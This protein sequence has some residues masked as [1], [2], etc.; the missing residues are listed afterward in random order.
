MTSEIYGMSLHTFGRK[1]II[2]QTDQ[3]RFVRSGSLLLGRISAI[4][5]YSVRFHRLCIVTDQQLLSMI[6]DSY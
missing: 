6:Q 1:I 5:S 4:E 2:E 3:L